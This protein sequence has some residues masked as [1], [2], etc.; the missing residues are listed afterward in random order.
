VGV[1]SASEYRFIFAAVLIAAAVALGV[2]CMQA[3]RER[4]IERH[5]P[6]RLDI[7]RAT[8]VEIEALPGMTPAKASA[9]VTY[10]EAHG[11]FKSADELAGVKGIDLEDVERLRPLV[12]AG[13]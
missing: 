2:T 13:G 7:N 5:P 1:W 4:S 12:K 9:V 6:S 8:E 10:R 11:P 3:R